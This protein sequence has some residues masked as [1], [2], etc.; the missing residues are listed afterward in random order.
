MNVRS[1]LGQASAAGATTSQTSGP[2][3]LNIYNRVSKDMHGFVTGNADSASVVYSV[4]DPMCPHCANLWMQSR[5]LLER[6]KFVWLPVPLLGNNS[7]VNGALIIAS[8]N[9]ADAMNV[10]EYKLLNQLPPLTPVPEVVE[11]GRPKMEHNGKISKEIKLDSVPFIMVKRA[12]GEVVMTVGGIGA[13]EIV[14]L[15]GQAG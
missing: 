5:L 1:S 12:S 15:L 3:L 11:A 14:T 6:V 4:I 9:P 7:L 8:A 10:H 13:P 2:E